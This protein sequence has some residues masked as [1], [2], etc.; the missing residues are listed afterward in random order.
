MAAFPVCHS[1]ACFLSTRPNEHIYNNATEHTK[2]VYVAGL[3]GVV[4][5][6]PGHSHQSVRDISALGAVPRLVMAEPS[7][8]QEVGALFDWCVNGST[9]S[10]YLRLV[11]VPWEV[12]FSLPDGYRPSPGR[13]VTLREG[14]DVVVI[15]YGPVLLSEAWH[16]AEQAAKEGV[17]VRLVNLPWLNRVDAEWLQDVTRGAQRIVTLDNHYIDG[18]QGDFICAAAASAGVHIPI[19]KVGLREIPVSG[20]N[21]D[22][23]RHHHLDR[24][25]L[26][27]TILS[28]PGG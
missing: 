1:F 2:V 10:A 25:S 27:E 13:G 7:T 18:G 28:Q 8:E 22:V 3:A 24:D 21:H 14:S 12:P 19:T 15:G 23:L 20:A 16:A 17:S 9:E 26:R 11:N 6:G 4:P 5:G